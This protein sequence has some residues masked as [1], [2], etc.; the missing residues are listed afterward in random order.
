MKEIM[1][2]SIQ[3]Y[4]NEHSGL[5]DLKS[6]KNDYKVFQNFVEGYFET[7]P[8]FKNFVL[9]VNEEGKLKG[10]EPSIVLSLNDEVIDVLVGNCFFTKV[11]GEDFVSLDINDV[12]LLLNHLRRHTNKRIFE[13]RIY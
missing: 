3:P 1:V 6:L 11:E 10:L 4:T 12:D 8:L 13:F 5:L 7:I 9:V 2:L